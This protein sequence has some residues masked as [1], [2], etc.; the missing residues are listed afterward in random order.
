M[1]VIMFVSFCAVAVLVHTMFFL[2]C[3]SYVKA[4]EK[5][6]ACYIVCMTETDNIVNYYHP[7]WPSM[8]LTR[9]ELRSVV[10]C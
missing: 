7:I 10:F 8:S 2:L 6:I 1:Y 5:C 9:D 3:G 4:A